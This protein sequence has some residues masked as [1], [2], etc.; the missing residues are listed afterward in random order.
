MQHRLVGPTARLVG[1]VGAVYIGA[2]FQAPAVRKWRLSLCKE[3]PLDAAVASLPALA[4]KCR[5]DKWG[6]P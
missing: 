3:G 2:L 4:R 6:Q 5:M 1:P